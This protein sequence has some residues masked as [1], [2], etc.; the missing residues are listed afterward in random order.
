[1]DSKSLSTPLDKDL[2]PSFYS[3]NLDHPQVVRE[4]DAIRSNYASAAEYRADNLVF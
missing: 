4:F 2:T 3:M 1:M